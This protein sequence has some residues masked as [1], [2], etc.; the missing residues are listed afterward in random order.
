M[1]SVHPLTHTLQTGSPAIDKAVSAGQTV[2]KDQLGVARPKGA[3]S[4]FGAVEK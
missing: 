1:Y 4:D 2:P 3:N